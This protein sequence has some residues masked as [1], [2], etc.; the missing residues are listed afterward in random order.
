MLF[1]QCCETLLT[2]PYTCCPKN[3]KLLITHTHTHSLFLE[4][5]L[6][7][8]TLTFILSAVTSL[9]P[10]QIVRKLKHMGMC[11]QTRTHTQ[12]EDTEKHTGDWTC[13]GIQSQTPLSDVRGL[14]IQSLQKTDRLLHPWWPV[15]VSNWCS[16]HCKQCF[17]FPRT[18]RGCVNCW[19]SAMSA[20]YSVFAKSEWMLHSLI[21][22]RAQD[23][24]HACMQ[25]LYPSQPKF[26]CDLCNTAPRRVTEAWLSSSSFRQAKWWGL[27]EEQ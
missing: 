14:K 12:R 15:P 21:S 1:L 4:R 23:C 25:S 3:L 6:S 24:L 16:T 17:R 27:Y 10:H 20:I 5:V 9:L 7:E 19:S 8:Y 18:H 22:W 11:T 2:R 26:V 13:P